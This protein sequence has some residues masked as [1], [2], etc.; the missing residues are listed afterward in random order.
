ML[1]LDKLS[2]LFSENLNKDFSSIEVTYKKNNVQFDTTN[3]NLDSHIDEILREN[4]RSKAEII[5]GTSLKNWLKD[6]TFIEES[7]GWYIYESSVGL[8]DNKKIKIRFLKNKISLIEI[9]PIGTKRTEYQYKKYDWSEKLVL[10]KVEKTFIDGSQKNSVTTSLGYSLVNK[11]YIVDEIKQVTK[12]AIGEAQGQVFKRE[13]IEI[14]RV[15]NVS[16]LK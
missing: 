4:I 14:Y 16:F 3:L 1:E 7:G 6:Y 12:Q 8:L 9:T 2:E 10:D 11:L 5:V 13:I 15:K